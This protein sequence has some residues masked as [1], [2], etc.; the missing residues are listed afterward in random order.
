MG[1]EILSAYSDS[2][3]TAMWKG[4]KNEDPYCGLGRNSQID[5]PF[6]ETRRSGQ[7]DILRRCNERK[8]TVPEV[9]PACTFVHVYGGP[10]RFKRLVTCIFA[11]D[12]SPI[13]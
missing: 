5:P 10:F 6:G 4:V 1:F 12:S 2:M 13:G 9:Y 8:V 3:A 7:D 11:S